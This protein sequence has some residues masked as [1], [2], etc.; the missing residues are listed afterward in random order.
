MLITP[1]TRKRVLSAADELF[2]QSQHRQMP[3]IDAVVK[4]AGTP[5]GD[6]AAVLREWLQSQMDFALEQAAGVPERVTQAGAEAL[7]ALWAEARVI[8]ENSFHAA[9]AIWEIERA[10]GVKLRT[11]LSAALESHGVE[12]VAAKIKVVEAEGKAATTLAKAQRE[13][14]ELSTALQAQATECE[15]LNSKLADAE[16][17]AA[18]EISRAARAEAHGAAELRER[19]RLAAALEAQSTAFE[20]LKT[21]SAGI[22][23]Q[24]TQARAEA[25]RVR[26]ESAQTIAALT[27]R[28]DTTIAQTQAIATRASELRSALSSTQLTVQQLTADLD[29]E[30]GQHEKARQRLA[31]LSEELSAMRGQS[32]AQVGAYTDQA[33]QLKRLAAELIQARR[34]AASAQDEVLR[35]REQSEGVTTQH[36]ELE[37]FMAARSK[38]T[39]GAK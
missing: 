3:S 34:A 29:A 27:E 12:L 2:E 5:P 14:L 32:N 11:A 17:K 16:V 13:R 22:E 15:A 30:R 10:E 25:E 38:S 31:A 26:I 39:K 20:A 6:T 24:A 19:L 23:L 36:A 7:S 35:I 28:S 33:E 37:R 18:Q 8:A 1:D 21:T 4:L 9:Q